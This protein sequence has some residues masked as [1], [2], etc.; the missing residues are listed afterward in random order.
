MYRLNTYPLIHLGFLHALLNTLALAPLLERF[1]AD[2]GTLLTAAMFVGRMYRFKYLGEFVV[3]QQLVAS[4]VHSPCG[5]LPVDR[6][7]NFEGKYSG[8]GRK[9]SIVATARSDY[10]VSIAT[11]TITSVWVFVLLGAEGIKAF[12]ANPYFACAHLEPS[13]CLLQLTFVQ[14]LAQVGYRRGPL[15]SWDLS[16]SPP[17]CP[18]HPFLGIFAALRSAISVSVLS[19]HY[20]LEAALRC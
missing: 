6:T 4:I 11:N 7:R 10:S 3:N 17:S 5:R 18:I 19:L 15:H 1:E 9:V 14:A 20:L 2:Q 13:L 12:R 16:S 8:H